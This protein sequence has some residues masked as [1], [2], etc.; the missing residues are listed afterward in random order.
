MAHLRARAEQRRILLKPVF[1][2]FD[3]W[4]NFFCWDH[5]SFDV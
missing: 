2:D 3:K 4:G 5:F 1:K